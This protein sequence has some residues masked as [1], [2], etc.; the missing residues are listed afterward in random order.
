MYNYNIPLLKVL[1]HRKNAI[2]IVIVYIYSYMY[3]V[4]SV[5]SNSLGL[6][7]SSIHRDSPGRNTRVGC[8]PPPRNLLNPGIEPTSLTSPVLASKFFM[9]STTGKL[10]I[11]I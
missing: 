3:A 1:P 11:F 6:P 7:V 8:H 4:V 10:D 5:L 9:T 2:A